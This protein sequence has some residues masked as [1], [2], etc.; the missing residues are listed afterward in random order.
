MYMYIYTYVYIYVY[1]REPPWL[2]N[3]SLR[4][5]VCLLKGEPHQ[6]GKY[7]FIY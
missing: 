7:Y 1:T 3:V 6:E 4:E 5:R 2:E